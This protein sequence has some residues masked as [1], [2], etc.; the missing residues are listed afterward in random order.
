MQHDIAH[1][2]ATSG[3]S[4][5][6]VPGARWALVLLLSMN[7]FNYIDRQMLAAVEPQIRESLVATNDQHAHAETGL[8]SSAFFVSYMLAAPLFGLLA[9]RWAPWKLIALGVALWSLAS[10]ASGLAATIGMLLV[11]RCF[12]GIGE[13]AYGPIAPSLLSDYFPVSIRGRILSWFYMALPVGGAA[14]Y[15]L[16]GWIAQLDQPGQS[17]RWGFYG[18]VAPGLALA[19]AALFTREPRRGA[20][21]RLA[22]PARR[23]SRRDYLVLLR[24]PSWVLDTLG[25]TGMSFAMG[26][27]AWWMPAYLQSHHAS[28]IWGLQPVLLF[29]LVTALAGLTGTLAGGLAGDWLRQ[30]FS[31][32]YFLVSGVGMLLSAPCAVIFLVVPFPAAWGFIFLAEFLLFL[33]TGPS[34][35]ILANVSHPSIRPTAFSLNILVIHLFGDVLSP[36]IIGA[37]ADRWSLETGFVAVAVIMAIGGLIWIWGARYLEADTEAAPTRLA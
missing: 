11:T 27:L 35:T 26:A 2:S 1:R 3:E 31:G 15:A 16:G 33:N 7:L 22:A 34:N 9:E 12:V 19:A 28:G 14:G 8:L 37:I 29:G 20:S 6:A 21:E 25:M 23:P 18:V 4:T 32:S 36:P 13:G 30:R 24:T 17:W 5:T 10:G